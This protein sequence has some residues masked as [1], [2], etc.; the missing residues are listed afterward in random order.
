MM[1]TLLLRHIQNQGDPALLVA[2]M[3]A[4]IRP[5]RA[6]D[7]SHATNMLRALCYIL[8]AQP[9]LRAA[10]RGTLQQLLES[11][12]PVSLYVESGVLPSTGFLAELHRRVSHKLLPDAIDTGYLRDVFALV[13]VRQ[14][15]DAWVAAVPDECWIELLTALRFE[16]QPSPQ[17]SPPQGLLDAVLVLSYRI[18]SIG[19]EPELVRN[20]PAL[21]EFASPFLTQNDEVHEYLK[22]YVLS[23][24]DPVQDFQDEKHIL[25]LLDQC[26]QVIQKIRRTASRSGTSI[27]LTFLLQRL[28]QQMQRMELLLAILAE[29]RQDRSGRRAYARFVDLFKTLVR[30]ECH[31]NDVLRYLQESMELLALRVTENASRTGEHYITESRS[32][33]F[34]L[35]RSAM[36]AGLI[37]AFMA[38][39]K[40]MMARQ[41]MAPLNEAILFSLN[42]GL[43]FIVI[44]LLHFSVA[45]K[46]PAMT[47]AT[48]AASIGESGGGARDMESL[49]SLI[50]QTM[51]SQ[52]VAIFGNVVLAVPMAMLIA[53]SVAAVTGTHFLTPEK[54]HRLLAETDPV[55]SLAVFYAAI[56]GVCLFLSGLIAGHHD[57]MAVYDR[58]PERIRQLRGL[59]RLL[60]EVRLSRM[61][62]YVEN[63]LGALAGNFYFG[64]L[65]G[66]MTAIGVLFGL[67]VDIRHVAFSSAN[68]GFSLVGLDFSPAPREILLA[69]LG[70]AVIGLT[71]LIVS[72]TLALYVAIKARK[73]TFANRHMLRQSLFR[74]IRQQP[75]E[76]LLPPKT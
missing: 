5:P 51:R 49:T 27:S 56:A 13:F 39:L 73:V 69:M 33:Y 53:W 75:Q 44:H 41:H 67:P 36:G 6:A 18:S 26:A 70:V 14:D 64:C 11:H 65:L 40:V 32:E 61:A 47:A 63:N 60:G 74:R 55:H 3:V 59:K 48:I 43:G 22:Q 7:A 28:T 68:L 15:D 71:N 29:L 52:L 45:T 17:G 66:G 19:L 46:Q 16:E 58:I 10:L 34:G 12:K 38:M 4:K 35:M 1:E 42:Y 54:A 24:Q 21:E 57:N 37:I 25:V 62:D 72:F 30:G 23:W 20:E 9:Q 31:K 50:A 2:E 8:D 76:F